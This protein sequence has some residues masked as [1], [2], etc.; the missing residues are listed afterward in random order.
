MPHET[1]L[2]TCFWFAYL[3]RKDKNHQGSV[4]LMETL[5]TE[6]TL[7]S[8]SELIVS[9]TYTLLMRK[10]G[11]SAALLFL[12]LLQQQVREGFT[13]IYWTDWQTLQSAHSILKKYADHSLSFTDAA[14]AA[15]I[16][17]R[18]L[19][20]IATYDRHFRL[21]NFPCLPEEYSEHRQL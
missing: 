13:K 17:R 18:R 20:A 6:G 10:L 2:D 4:R 11:T 15:L 5:M 16:N 9:E 21:M 1:F 12:G 8:T 14:T 19:P 7:L 3:V